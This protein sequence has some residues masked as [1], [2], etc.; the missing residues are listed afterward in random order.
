M[1]EFKRIL[2]PLD[3][4]ALSESALPLALGLAQKFESH[5]L[6]LRVAY[7]T[8]PETALFQKSGNGA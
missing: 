7:F 8:L 1:I 2:L 6:L 4:S 3:G 5:I